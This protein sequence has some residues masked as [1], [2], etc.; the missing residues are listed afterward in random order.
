METQTIKIWKKT[1][2]ELRLLYALTGKSMVSILD[3]LVG[4]ELKRVL[5]EK[6]EDCD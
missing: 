1:L 6:G 4:R 5:G 2:K 3:E